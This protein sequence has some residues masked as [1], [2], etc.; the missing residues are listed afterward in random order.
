MGL[1][2]AGVLAR[3]FSPEEFGLWSILMSLN[4]ILLNGFDFGFGNALRNKLAQLFGRKETVQQEGPL[5]FFSIFYWFVITALILTSIFFLLKPLIPWAVLFRSQEPKIVLEGAS[6]MILGASILAFNISFNIYSSGFFAFQESHWNALLN[7]L[8]RGGLLAAILFFV[9]ARW[10]FYWINLMFF[11][12]TLAASILSFFLFLRVRKWGWPKISLQSIW[13]KVGEL[14]RPSLQFALLQTFST[15]V[16]NLDYFIVGK[17]LG[18]EVVGDYFLVKRIYLVVASFHFALLLPVWSAYTESIASR[19][20]AWA[21]KSL[22]QTTFYTII[23]FSLALLL[24]VLWGNSIVYLW[25]GKEIQTRS[26]FLW[27]GV[28]GWVYGWGNCFS[29]FLNGT[30]N[31]RRQVI[32][33]GA[34]ALI[35]IPLSLSLGEKLGVAGVGLALTLVSLPAAISNPL[36]SISVLKRFRKGE[37]TVPDFKEK[38]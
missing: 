21:K 1:I 19:D 20:F 33:A 5:Y 17:M 8:S 14:W 36:Q 35:L 2:L 29:V 4:G 7:G 38:F 27:L 24:M 11:V 25:T 3:Y 34:A 10:P 6:L 37:E 13:M 32:W 9:L 22:R 31:L 18:L 12:I 16:L 28:W 23:I 30:G 15:F 26:L